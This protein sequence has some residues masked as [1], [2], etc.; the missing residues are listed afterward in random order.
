MR[1]PSF[2][3]I[4]SVA[5]W[6]LLSLNGCQPDSNPVTP[7]SI[8]L[9]GA[10]HENEFERALVLGDDGKVVC[11]GTRCR[12]IDDTLGVGIW[13]TAGTIL[14][15]IGISGQL[16]WPGGAGL[17]AGSRA[18]F[19][20]DLPDDTNLTLRPI[21]GNTVTYTRIENSIAST[22]TEDT[23]LKLLFPRGGEL[24]TKSD[25]MRIRW[26]TGAQVASAVVQF[27]S[28]DGKS[29]WNICGRSVV[30]SDTSVNT[31]FDWV[32][33]PFDDPADHCYIQI[34]NY[35]NRDLGFSGSEVF[36]IQ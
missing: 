8:I 11:A 3:L 2:W 34:F 21:S 24:F 4:L 20:F 16:W 13:D 22:C 9:T 35:A 31:C 15:L 5:C 23:A 27:S 25:T 30:T 29:F 32:I 28:D 6:S 7:Q 33:E 26:R 10:W 36:T 19:E 12:Q 18:L 1:N 14:T 17:C